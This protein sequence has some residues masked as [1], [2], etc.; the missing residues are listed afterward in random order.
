MFTSSSSRTFSFPDPL[1]GLFST[2][3]SPY[4]FLYGL[5]FILSSRPSSLFS[6]VPTS[7]SFVRWQGRVSCGTTPRTSSDHLCR[8]WVRVPSR[9]QVRSSVLEPK[10]PTSPPCTS[11]YTRPFYWVES[12]LHPPNELYSSLTSV[13]VVHSTEKSSLFLCRPLVSVVRLPARHPVVVL[14]TVK[15]GK[16][17]EMFK[18]IHRFHETTMIK[19]FSHLKDLC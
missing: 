6:K 4:N 10:T 3:N 14:V 8:R 18:D 2:V 13:P 12:D 17:G 7:S 11:V 9:T 16:R 1:Q 5:D 15:S 19:R